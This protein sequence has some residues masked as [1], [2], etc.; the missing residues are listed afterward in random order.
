MKHQIF[1]NGTILTQ[2]K[3]NPHATAFTIEDGKFISVGSD[4]EILQQQNENTAIANLNQQTVLPG[5]NDAHI[6]IWKVGNLLTNM[7]DLRGVKSVEQLL[8]LL[9]DYGK[10]NPSFT[11]IQ[12]RGFNEADFPD[13]R[14]PDKRDLDK[15]ISDRPVCITRICAHQIIVNTKA[16]EI[17][18]LDKSIVSPVGG[19]IKYLSDGTLA[20]HFTETAIGLVLSKI[21]KYKA[22]EL[23]T[24]ILAA[25]KEFIACGITSATDPAVDRDLLE[26][27]K[28]MDRQG[29]LKIRV[30]A[31]P[32]R[33][34]DGAQKIYP[35]PEHYTSDHLVVNTVK[36]FA[37][38]GLSGRTAALKQPYKHSDNFGVL[39]LEKKKFLEL[40]LESQRAGF[41]IATHAIGDA[42]IELVMD[43]YEEISTQS[44]QIRHRIEHLGLPSLNDLR[45][46]QA[47]Q[48][49]A[50]M[51]PVF[52]QEL[53]KNFLNDVPDD[54]LAY[55]YPLR[56]V[57][58]HKIPLA[59]STDAPV[60]KNFKPFN[61][62]RAAT[63]RATENNH[64][65]GPDQTITTEESIYAYTMGSAIANGAEKMTGSIEP[66]KQADFIIC[67]LDGPDH[68]KLH[69]VYISGSLQ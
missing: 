20:G 45:R 50:V 51:Q 69:S 8:D 9:N 22:D 41:K 23:R 53:G 66:G 54:Y 34:P 12:A 44:K 13:R 32:I 7:L 58:Q 42:A 43:V 26:V 31:I 14:M 55:L 36:F 18:G 61:N 65:I 16:L 59:F 1:Y 30:N 63:S 19:E 21:P 5:F 28:Q 46:M 64:L 33:V 68:M 27:Y 52:I 48:V 24:M 38:G 29:E 37:D 25:Q 15:I 67:D 40:A 47:M 2:D 17:C 60:V 56:S 49:S 3:L 39:R 4:E 10:A 11:W 35:V 57:I 62:I 6:H